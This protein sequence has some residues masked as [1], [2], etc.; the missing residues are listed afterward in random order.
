M[1]RAHEAA[2]RGTADHRITERVDLGLD[3][4]D[5]PEHRATV[6]AWTAALDQAGLEI[7]PDL[8]ER[9]VVY[10]DQMI[11]GRYDRIARYRQTGRHVIADVK[12]GEN[13]IK[14]PHATIVQLA[15]YANAPLQAVNL[16]RRRNNK[17]DWVEWTDT[18]APL[19][20]DLHRDHAVVVYLPPE[21]PA[22]CYRANIARGWTEAAKAICFPT[23]GWRKV[24]AGDLIEPLGPCLVAPLTTPERHQWIRDRI[25]SIVTAGHEAEL[26]GIWDTSLVQIPL[27]A[28]TPLSDQQIDTLIG[29]CSGIEA[30]A[31]L[32]FEP[33]DP[34][35]QAFVP[36]PTEPMLAE[37]VDNGKAERD[38]EAAQWAAKAR[39]LMAPFDDSEQAAIVTACLMDGHR[40]HD[41]RPLYPR[42]S[43][44]RSTRRSRRRRPVHLRRQG[45]HR[46]LL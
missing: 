27:A 43:H 28:D 1:A 22:K 25:R 10:P 5:T 36:R 6:A 34:L 21:G 16:R 7:D 37:P 46:R 9:I 31:G 4:I 14:Y 33:T 32:P 2:G 24:P 40:A 38:E 30:L 26:A 17:G 41:L 20:D 42:R 45:P 15:L 18:F 12:T 23:I 13:A 44:D 39:A 11:A 29:W 3:W 8:V 19:P 35:Y